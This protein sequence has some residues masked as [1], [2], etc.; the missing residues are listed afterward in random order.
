M[1]RKALFIILILSLMAAPALAKQTV[2]ASKD[3]TPVSVGKEK[4]PAPTR[5]PRVFANFGD[6]WNAMSDKER[7]SFLEGY[8]MAFHLVCTNV[9]M[10][11]AGQNNQAPNQQEREKQLTNCMVANLPFAPSSTKA[12]L[13]ELYQD[14]A[15]NHM[16]F[17]QMIGI[18]FEKMAGHPYEENLA[19]LR[20]I[21]EAQLRS[22]K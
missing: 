17:D 7:D 22:G 5:Q 15:N 20:Q 19:K 21:V 3:K 18:A 1:A 4:A 2:S 11:S 16:P 6:R 14:S 8:Y 13:T 10:A 9:A 12:V